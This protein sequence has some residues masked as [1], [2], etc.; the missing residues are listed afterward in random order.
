MEL[1]NENK[2]NG[3]KNTT[4]AIAGFELIGSC[5]AIIILTTMAIDIWIE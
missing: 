4:S 2:D 5:Y 3:I 1:I